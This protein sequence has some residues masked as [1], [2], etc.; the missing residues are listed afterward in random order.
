MHDVLLVSTSRIAEDRKRC[1][2]CG[3]NK[4][5][6]RLNSGAEIRAQVADAAAAGPLRQYPRQ[7]GAQVIVGVF[8]EPFVE[9]R[10]ARRPRCGGGAGHRSA[11][12]RFPG[13]RLIRR[14]SHDPVA[15]HT[16]KTMVTKILL[17]RNKRGSL[18]SDGPCSHLR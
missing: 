15:Q 5:E 3:A 1:A 16:L 12:H 14:G 13:H 4:G 8:R 10:V 18:G 2:G 17:E 7:I 6:H 9:K 11:C